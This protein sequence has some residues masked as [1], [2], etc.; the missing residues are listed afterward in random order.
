MT[1]L[2][3]VRRLDLG[4]FIRPAEEAGTPHPRV[5]AVLAYLVDTADGLL[6]FDTGLGR[7]DDETEA[8]YRP[9]RRPLPEALAEAGVRLDDIALVV[10]CHLHFDHIGG[11]PLLP[12]RPIFTQS[13]ELATARA[14][15]YTFDQLVDF[16]GADL[17]ELDG[18]VEIAPGIRI[19]PTP[20]H[21]AGHQSLLVSHA[22][23]DVTVLAGQAYDLATDFSCAVL[24]RR[25]AADGAAAPLPPY[26][27]WLDTLTEL[28][29]RRVLFAHDAAVWHPDA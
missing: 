24:A 2:N 23:G 15:D 4:Y 1:E 22:D 26:H 17:R 19:V 14:G 11:N 20:G 10:N 9:H 16:P 8:H 25:A 18:T 27:P 5:E 12:G 13:V 28:N 29:P 3:A 6:L 7:G 21:T